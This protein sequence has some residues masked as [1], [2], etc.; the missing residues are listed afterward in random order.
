[1]TK[2]FLDLNKFYQTSLETDRYLI[3]KSILTEQNLDTIKKN[4]SKH[5]NKLYASTFVVG[6][7]YMILYDKSLKKTMMT[8]HEF[9]ML[10]NQ[11]FLDNAKG[12]VLIFGLGIGL[13][14]FPLLSDKDVNSITIVETDSG[15]VNA[16]YPIIKNKDHHSKL[17]IFIE[18]AFRFE[19]NNIYDTIYFDIWHSIDESV[20]D[21][22]RLL[23]KK[24][25][26]N[27]TPD[28]W[29]DSW[30]SEE[31]IFYNEFK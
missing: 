30:C 7:E 10:T 2:N 22:M 1:M 12:D 23:S 20:F 26:N 31:E 9:E 27:L 25:K 18:D 4:W 14:V 19:T 8:S 3:F 29:M 24:F 17:S 6:K 16:V 11:K 21:E 13:I 15:L 28:G 5:R